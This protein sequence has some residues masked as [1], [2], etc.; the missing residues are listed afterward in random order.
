MTPAKPQH[1][2]TLKH[3]LRP[4]IDVTYRIGG[5]TTTLAPREISATLLKDIGGKVYFRAYRAG[6]L[7]ASDTLYVWHSNNGGTSWPWR[8]TRE[9]IGGTLGAGEFFD[10]VDEFKTF[11]EAMGEAK[12][13]AR[14]ALG[15]GRS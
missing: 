14:V 6:A 4:R 8:V 9:R 3:V 1:T 15:K 13:L 10:D 11:R 2:L 7:V 12:R 5:E